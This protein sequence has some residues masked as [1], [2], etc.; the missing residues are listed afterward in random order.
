MFYTAVDQGMP[1][2]SI[3]ASPLEC[4]GLGRRGDRSSFDFILD[5]MSDDRRWMIRCLTR[6]DIGRP[7]P[8]ILYSVTTMLMFKGIAT[9]QSFLASFHA[10]CQSCP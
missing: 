5:D 4:L 9:A 8:R 1:L 6:R 3:S 2:T 10:Q 7:C